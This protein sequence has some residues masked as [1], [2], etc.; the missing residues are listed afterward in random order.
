VST[1]EFIYKGLTQEALDSEYNNL[2]KISNAVEIINLWEERGD[3]ACALLP[4]KLDV[5]YGPDEMQ[6]MDIFPINKPMSPILAFIHGGYWSSRSK[7]ISRFLAPF[8]TAAGVNFISIGYRLCPA[9][10]IGS[11]VDD[12]RSCLDWIFENAGQF[13]GDNRQIFVAGHSAGGH[14]TGLMCGPSGPTYL[15]GG[16]SLSGIHD[17]EPIRLSYLNAQIR[18]TTDEVDKYSPVR[19]VENVIPDEV[20]LPPLIIAVGAKEGQEYLYQTNCFTD[21]L[22]LAKQPVLK[23]I[24][25]DG[26]HFS[27]CES[28]CDPS[29]SLSNEVL[30]LI[31]A[32]RF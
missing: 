12:I 17:L 1:T 11:I 27:V 5:K 7:R 10:R 30:K 28:F 4:C 18:L 23:S 19:V 32:P 22:N 20:K 21:A 13:E 29:S 14:L 24:I 2:N 6:S 25:E 16:C 8:Y 31:F 26:N 15:K 3:E 9:V